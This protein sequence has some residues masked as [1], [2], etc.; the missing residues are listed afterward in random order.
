MICWSAGGGGTAKTTRSPSRLTLPNAPGFPMSGIPSGALN[1][2]FGLPNVNVGEVLHVYGHDSPIRREV[3][4]LLTVSPPGHHRQPALVGH[5]PR[6]G[7]RGTRAGLTCRTRGP[8]LLILPRLIRP[9]CNKAAVG[10]KT[11]AASSFSERAILNGLRDRQ[12]A[13]ACTRVPPER[14][15]VEKFRN[16]PSNDQSLKVR[17]PPG[18]W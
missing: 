12:T 16:R 9:V 14:S 13:E 1:N 4:E 18:C 8:R 11:G 7:R 17:T 10:G 2:S 5:L 15:I 6:A 3:V